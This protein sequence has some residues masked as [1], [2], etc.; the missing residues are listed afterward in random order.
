MIDYREASPAGSPAA[1]VQEI[2]YLVLNVLNWLVGQFVLT[3]KLLGRFPHMLAEVGIAVALLSSGLLSRYAPETWEGA[4]RFLGGINALPLVLLMALALL[5]GGWLL[6]QSQKDALWLLTFLKAG[7]LPAVGLWA[8]TTNTKVQ[9]FVG[10]GDPDLTLLIAVK[11]AVVI[12]LVDIVLVQSYRPQPR[13]A[14]R[15]ATTVAAGAARMPA[16][17]Q[18]LSYGPPADEIDDDFSDEGPRR[19]S[20]SGVSN[21]MTR[22][23]QPVPK[24]GQ[25]PPGL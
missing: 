21:L 12:A 13:R 15:A 7:P 1:M 4:I 24:P 17:S 18:R 20:L 23:A 10:W 25:R 8:L 3:L 2:A 22:P 9:E 16:P 19:P 6:I 14:Q 5:N 11:L